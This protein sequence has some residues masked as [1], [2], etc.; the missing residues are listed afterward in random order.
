MKKQSDKRVHPRIITKV[1]IKAIEQAS[2]ALSTG[3][4]LNLSLGGVSIETLGKMT[5]GS[6]V[7]IEFEPIKGLALKLKGEV[8]WGRAAV[9]K[10]AYGVK[11]GDMSLEEKLKLDEYIIANI[12]GKPPVLEEKRDSPRLPADLTMEIYSPEGSVP[13]G[14]GRLINVSL[15]GAGVETEA[16]FDLGD[17]FVLRVNLP[18]KKKMSMIGNVARVEAKGEVNLYGIRFSEIDMDDKLKL[19]TYVEAKFKEYQK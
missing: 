12:E 3:E 7:T 10:K 9:K 13:S 19:E 16:E 11:F 1:E 2:A 17:S 6:P 18:N 4:I 5:I 8:V 14:K 15:Q